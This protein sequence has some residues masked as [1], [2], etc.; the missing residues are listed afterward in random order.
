MQFP[1]SIVPCL[2]LAAHLCKLPA[3]ASISVPQKGTVPEA[4]LE[5]L[6]QRLG[7]GIN[8]VHGEPLADI[9]A[10]PL[11]GPVALP[12]KNGASVLF[13]GKVRGKP[14]PVSLIRPRSPSSRSI[15]PLPI[16]S[17]N[18][19]AWPCCSP[20]SASPTGTSRPW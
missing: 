13:V 19:R 11:A 15:S 7:I 17:P 12:L 1:T 2:A 3:P 5:A 8:V 16:W 10:R 4:D 14:W 20:P 18:G 6:A 9:A